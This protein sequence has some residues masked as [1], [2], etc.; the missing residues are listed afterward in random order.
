MQKLYLYGIIHADEDLNFGVLDMKSETPNIIQGKGHRGLAI[1]FSNVELEEGEEM[2]ATRKNLLNHQKVIE[3][4]ME[5]HNIL[6]FAFGMVV[7]D[8][9]ALKSAIDEK[10]EFFQEKLKQIEGKIELNLK[11]VWN[12]MSMVY[13]SITNNNEEIKALK[14]K[15]QGQEKPDQADLIELGK[16][17][18]YGLT[19]E[20]ERMSDRIIDTL[21]DNYESY[22]LNKN[23]AENMFCN[24]AFMIDASREK[25]FDEAINEIGETMKEN[26]TF[27]YVGPLPPYNFLD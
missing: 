7:D 15:L 3:R 11:G 12:D 10:Y 17:V 13:E 14:A 2:Q 1:V 8:E 27:K 18:E 23:I 22:R 25:E 6:P 19:L 5:A 4:V 9:D 16:M 20:K 26:T 21:A 24:L